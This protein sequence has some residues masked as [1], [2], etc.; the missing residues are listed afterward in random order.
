VARTRA[1]G[2]R[3]IRAVFITKN[4]ADVSADYQLDESSTVAPA[5]DAHGVFTLSKPKAVGPPAIIAWNFTSTTRW[6]RRKFMISK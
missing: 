2:S 4:V 1:A 3:Q 6:P 5:P